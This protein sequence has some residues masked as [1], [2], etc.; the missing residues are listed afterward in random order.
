VVLPGSATV[1]VADTTK[2]TVGKYAYM[3]RSADLTLGSGAD[4]NCA[5]TGGFVRKFTS[6]TGTFST[7]GVVRGDLLTITGGG[8]AGT[9][10]VDSVVSEHELHITS[11]FAAVSGAPET[12]SVLRRQGNQCAVALITK[13]NP[14]PVSTLE[15]TVLA[16]NAAQVDIGATIGDGDAYIKGRAAALAFM[17]HTSLKLQETALA[18]NGDT[19]SAADAQTNIT[20]ELARVR[21][22]MSIWNSWITYGKII[23]VTGVDGQCLNAGVTDTRFDSA[24]GDFVNNGV[25]AGDTLEISGGDN[26]GTYTVDSVSGATRIDV[27]VAREFVT[28]PSAGESYV[29]AYG[30]RWDTGVLDLLLALLDAR[31][32]ERATRVSQITASAS[33]V[34]A[35]R[36]EWI[37]ALVNRMSGSW[38][39]LAGTQNSIVAI[40]NYL[41][42]AGRIQDGYWRYFNQ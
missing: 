15:I 36:A 33:V 39:K 7:W 28:V 34:Y 26:A 40:T 4:G 13:I 12:Y 10:V 24:T 3:S 38:T 18:S 21:Y 30:V 27:A 37:N 23:K 32:S 6:A 11:V 35:E 41:E 8:N 17:V 19:F 20:Y 2:F 5:S 25:A 29:I 22:A 9:Y 14:A 31:A 16:M 1:K 42:G